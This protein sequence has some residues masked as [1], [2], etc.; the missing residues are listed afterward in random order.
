M[1]RQ[2]PRPEPRVHSYFV[3]TACPDEAGTALDAAPYGGAE[4]IEDGLKSRLTELTEWAITSRSLAREYFR[5]A[6]RFIAAA[7]QARRSSNQAH[8]RAHLDEARKAHEQARKCL[9]FSHLCH[10]RT[11]CLAIIGDYR[12]KAGD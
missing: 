3:P 6:R 2:V 4:A 10:K 9:S 11:E 7:R 5:T 12:P 1:N 8:Y